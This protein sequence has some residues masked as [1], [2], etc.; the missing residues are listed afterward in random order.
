MYRT[1]GTERT[2]MGGIGPDVGDEKDEV[3]LDTVLSVRPH[4]LE[5]FYE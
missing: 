1:E 4:S 2:E 3:S 5:S